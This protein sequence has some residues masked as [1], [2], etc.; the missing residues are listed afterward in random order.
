MRS[1]T[2]LGTID[3]VLGPIDEPLAIIAKALRA[4]ILEVDPDAT[5]QPRPG[6][7]SLSYGVGSRK[8][9]DGY[10]YVMPHAQHVN[11]GFYEGAHLP[12]PTGLLAGTGKGL[13]HVKVRSLADASRPE[14][15]GLIEAALARRK[16]QQ[17]SG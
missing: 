8:M 4:L 1:D 6:D 11:L 16:S 5:E 3:D 13:R 14:L 10:A 15:R 12:D 2:R 7:R 9:I 17:R